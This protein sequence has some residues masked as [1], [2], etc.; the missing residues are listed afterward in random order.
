MLA[1][2]KA[3]PDI[4]LTL[5]SDCTDAVEEG[6]AIEPEPTHAELHARLKLSVELV[7]MRRELDETKALVNRMHTALVV[8]GIWPRT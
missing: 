7:K 6:V 1:A 4:P 8:A 3:L 2:D 5:M